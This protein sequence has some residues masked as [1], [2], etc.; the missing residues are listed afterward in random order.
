MAIS[1]AQIPEQVDIFQE[2]GDVSSSLT[3][4]D[5]LGLYGLVD[6]PVTQADITKEIEFIS[7]LMPEP[8]KQNIF[9]LASDIGTGLVAS[10]ADPRG[11]GAGL[12]AGFSAFNQRKKLLEETKDKMKQEI[13]MA[14]FQ[15]VEDKRKE[16]L[17][18]TKEILEMQF[19]AA[20]KDK[21][22]DIDFGST[23]EGKALAFVVRAELN[24]KLKFIEDP[25]NPGNYIDNPEYVFAKE[26]AKRDRIV[27]GPEGSFTYPGADVDGIL[28]QLTPQ[29]PVP[30]NTLEQDGVTWTFT[31]NFDANGYPIYNDGEVDRAVE[32]PFIE[33]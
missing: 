14:A 29:R 30:P 27:T 16:Q 32:N 11:I 25:N 20:L 10:A 24:P 5:I 23:M 28:A 7:G 31:G 8:K 6:Q 21:D 17:A 4:E 3:A 19:E 33:K 15:R 26:V 12:T 2:G 18:T 9:D 13:A 22:S 1:R